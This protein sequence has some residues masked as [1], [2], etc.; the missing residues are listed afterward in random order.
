MNEH[1]K[2]YPSRPTVSQPKLAERILS[3]FSGFSLSEDKAEDI[4]SEFSYPMDGYELAKVLEK[5][6]SWDVSRDAMEAL[7]EID[8][9]YSK[10]AEELEKEWVDTNAIQPPFPVGTMVEFTQHLTL[11]IGKITEVYS[12]GAAKYCI[13]PKGQDDE[14]ENHRRFIVRFEDV[15]LAAEVDG[16]TA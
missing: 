6:C 12:H 2:Q 10:L 3:E 16:G 5:W 8:S 9:I 15:S 4:A 7:D 11:S 13:K 1:M 14:K